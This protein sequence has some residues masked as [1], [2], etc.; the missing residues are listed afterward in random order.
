MKLHGLLPLHV[1]HSYLSIFSG[2][3]FAGTFGPSEGLICFL[4]SD[5]RENSI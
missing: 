4:I 1:L 5:L 3:M 2:D